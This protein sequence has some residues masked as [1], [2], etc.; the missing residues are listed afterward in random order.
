M[1]DE[2]RP[3]DSSSST[4]DETADKKVWRNVAGLV[5]GNTVGEVLSGV[6]HALMTKILGPAG[7]GQVSQATAVIDVSDGIAAFGLNQVGPVLGVEYEDRLGRYLGTILGFRS[8]VTLL[9]IAAVALL[10]PMVR[11]TEPWIVRLA[12]LA[13]LFSPLAGTATVPF[14]LR[15]DN[16]KI[17]WLPGASGLVNLVLLGFVLWLAPLVEWVVATTIV[18]RLF[19]AAVIAEVARRRYRFRYTFDRTVLRRL[20]RVS[21]KAAWLDI[22]VI[23]Y[24]KASYFVLDGLGAVMLGIYAVAD[25]ISQPIL[26][27]TGALSAASLP[28]FAE[29]GKKSGVRELRGFYLRNIRRVAVALAL[30]AVV[31]FLLV[32]PVIRA[33][34]AEYSESLPVLYVLYIGV[35]FMAVNQMTSSCLNGIGHFGWVAA[36]ATVNLCVYGVGVWLWVPRHAAFGAALATTVMEGCNSCMQLVLL[37]IALRRHGAR[38]RALGGASPPS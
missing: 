27:V 30:I 11:S 3:G 34:F 36:V 31:I 9:V 12:A 24:S 1:T 14:F 13:I 4:K 19:H 6:V 18:T 22:V 15:Q 33:W 2:P 28:M 10:A 37:T 8:V 17:A 5:G 23:T 29:L 32:P 35:C 7:Y 26:R 21:P 16:W 25:K 20:L 38:K